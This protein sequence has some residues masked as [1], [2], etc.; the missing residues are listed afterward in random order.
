MPNLELLK[1]RFLVY[2]GDTWETNDGQFLQLKFLLI[3]E[4]NHQHW[5]TEASH[6]P[7]LKSLV[8]HRCPAAI[9]E[10]STLELIEVDDVNKSL[11]DS[12]KQIQ[13]DQLEN[14]G[15]NAFQ[16]RCTPFNEP[17]A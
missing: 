2:D 14:Y 12:A 1:L 4:S 11:V 13:E 15:N 16:V 10:I 8:L 17:S 3:E 7:R 5:I 9:G 6:F